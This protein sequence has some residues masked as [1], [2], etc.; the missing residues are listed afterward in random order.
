[1]LPETQEPGANNNP[2]P[3]PP[4]PPPPHH[5]P[6]PAVLKL[7]QEQAHERRHSAVP[8]A[9][10]LLRE[11][12]GGGS[13]K[14]RRQ[15]AQ[16]TA[17]EALRL[18]QNSGGN[19]CSS[20][21]RGSSSTPRPSAETAAHS[22]GPDPPERGGTNRGVRTGKNLTLGNEG[23]WSHFPVL[24]GNGGVNFHGVGEKRG[25]GVGG[26]GRVEFSTDTAIDGVHPNASVDRQTRSRPERRREDLLSAAFCATE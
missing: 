6:L 16:V 4:P 15:R 11:C 12:G 10:R 2:D 24:E 3:T 13:L 5:E 20:S 26:E 19:Y 7:L 22:L 18:A 14:V 1:M 17:L 8:L 25:S 9:A 21:R 23:S